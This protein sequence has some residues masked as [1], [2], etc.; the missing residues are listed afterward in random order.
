MNRAEIITAMARVTEIEA[1]LAKLFPTQLDLREDLRQEAFLVLCEMPAE[2]LAELWADG[3][4]TG[5]LRAYLLGT[6][7]LMAASKYS[8]FYYQYR[9]KERLNAGEQALAICS[10]DLEADQQDIENKRLV[11]ETLA[12][13]EDTLKKIGAVRWYDE[14]LFRL[15]VQLGCNSTKVSRETHIPR[16]SVVS[17]VNRVLAVIRRAVNEKKTNDG[18]GDMGNSFRRVLGMVPGGPV[19]LALAV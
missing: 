6:I 10:R 16:P 8:R 13:A 2:R 4:A 17:T 5:R 12:L 14:T 3:G 15:Y 1:L 19:Q 7:R 9:K 18:N 11:E